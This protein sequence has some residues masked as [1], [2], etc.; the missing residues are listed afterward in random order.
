[1]AMNIDMSQA[2]VVK[3][4]QGRPFIV[5][6]DQ[7]KKKRQHGNEAVKSHILAARTVANIVKT[8]LGPRGLDKILISP[9]GDITVTNDGATILGQMEI[10][11]HVAKLL[12]ELSKSQDDEIGDGTT[13]VVVLAGALLEQAAELIDKGI[14]PIR[15][16]DGLGSKI[17]SKA[18]DQFANI[19]VDAILSVADLERKDVDFD[20]IKVDGKVGGSLE[21]SLLVQG[22]IVDKDFSH[23]QMPDEVRDAKIAIL[24]CAFEPPKPKTKH[25]LDI[26]SVE[27]FKKLQTYEKDKFTE[28]VQ[29]IKD[30]G[31][32]LCSVRWVGGPEIEL[33][34]IATNGRIVPRFEDLSAEKL[35]RAGV[36]REMSFGTTREK[37]LVIEECANTR[38]VTVFVRGSNKMIIDE[39]KRSLHDAL[40]VVRNL[41]RDN[42]VVYGGGAAEI[43]CS[44]AVEDAAVKSPGLEQYAMRA[45]ADALDAIPMA[46][47]ENSGLS[48]I[49]TLASVKSRQ[50]T[51]KNTRLGVDCMQTGSNDMR[52]AFVI[53]PLIGKKQQLMLATQLCRMVLKINNVIIAD[54]LMSPTLY[55]AFVAYGNQQTPSVSPTLWTRMRMRMKMDADA[56]SVSKITLITL[57]TFATLITSFSR[58]TLLT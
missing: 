47:A 52:D 36:V 46:L 15:I 48:S 34:A 23:P 56:Y 42:R 50:A 53:D 43:A 20:L 24:T 45:F 32:N 39:A 4:E 44:L 58:F 6:R 37:M 29:Q 55:N 16:A 40:C 28:M 22:V 33:I 8:S 14:H 5:V 2:S 57:T 12:V 25:K 17:V 1:M 9:D 54:I 41:V 38:A 26:T 27:E 11:N 10:Q 7:G 18:H 30:T 31:A 35:G 21:D 13:G 51:E 49:E 3:D 19:A